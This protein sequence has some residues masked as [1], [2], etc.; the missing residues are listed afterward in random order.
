MLVIVVV[1]VVVD[2]ARERLTMQEVWLVVNVWLSMVRRLTGHGARAGQARLV[3][4]EPK[5]HHHTRPHARR[6]GHGGSWVEGRV[7]G[8]G[9]LMC[10]F[11]R[12]ELGPLGC[13]R[14]PA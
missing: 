8:Q 6:L 1:V 12:A 13:W 11:A 4:L 5:A 7:S 9:Q 2:Q 14:H 3:R 10:V